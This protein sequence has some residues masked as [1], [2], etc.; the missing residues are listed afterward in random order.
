MEGSH[1][2]MRKTA[3][4]G[5]TTSTGGSL[6]PYA[7]Q[8]FRINGR[9]AAIICGRAT[10]PACKSVG[11]IAK[12]GGPRRATNAEGNQIALEGDVV[13]CKCPKHPVLVSLSSFALRNDDMGTLGMDYSPDA[14]SAEWFSSVV[15]PTTATPLQPASATDTQHDEY[16]QHFELKDAK[17]GA[18]LANCEYRII[19]NDVTIQAFTDENGMTESIS[20]DRDLDV[21]IEIV[22]L[23]ND[24]A[25]ENGENGEN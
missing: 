6:L 2:M 22:K 4:I 25:D 24:A 10:C 3:C 16:D 17:T 5:D 23:G 7:G 18:P 9:Q 19:S 8:S 11:L 15:K 1:I 14:L 13:L 21:I 20:A 12:A